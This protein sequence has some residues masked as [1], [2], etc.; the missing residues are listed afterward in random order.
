MQTKK[1]CKSKWKIRRDF[2]WTS[3]T[4]G[5]TKVPSEEE[6]TDHGA[7]EEQITT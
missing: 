5:T 4:G 1:K 6:E 3:K 2:E 7:E